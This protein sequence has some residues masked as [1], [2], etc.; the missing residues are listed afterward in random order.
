MPEEL[1]TK[2]KLKAMVESQIQI[3]HQICKEEEPHKDIRQD[4]LVHES[5]RR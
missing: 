1:D 2:E 5:I 4:F 3:L